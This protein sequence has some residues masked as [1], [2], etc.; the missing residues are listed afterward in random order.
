[1]SVPFSGFAASIVGTYLPA[2]DSEFFG[3]RV[4]LLNN[5]RPSFGLQ[6]KTRQISPEERRPLALLLRSSDL[7]GG[8]FVA[9]Q[10]TRAPQVPLSD[11]RS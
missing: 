5:R 6:P 11:R 9:D 1:M 10:L 8:G 2:L 4:T 7:T 3:P